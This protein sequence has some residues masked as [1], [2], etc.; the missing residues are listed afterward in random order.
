MLKICINIALISVFAAPSWSVADS[1]AGKGSLYDRLGGKSVVS[2]IANDLVDRVEQNPQTRRTFVKVN[3]KRIKQKIEEQICALAGG[4]CEYT[5]DTMRQSHAGLDITEA[6]F[7]GLVE[8]LIRVLD[9]HKIGLQEK[10]QLLAL[11]A[12]MKHEIVTR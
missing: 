1:P 3:I 5:G 9:H 11:L 10:N 7:Y 4:P 6:E 8:D 2:Q 12:P